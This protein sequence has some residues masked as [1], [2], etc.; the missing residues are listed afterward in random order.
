M[1]GPMQPQGHFQ[2]VR[3]LV[4]EGDDPQAA[5][6]APR[7]RVE[8]EGYVEL[9]PGLAD[10]GRR[11]PGAGPRRPGRRRA[12]PVRRRPGDPAPRGRARRRLGRPRR[13]LRRGFLVD[14]DLRPDRHPTADRGGTV[15]LL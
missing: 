9:E 14:V 10:R 13:R 5:L 1:G 11:P 6:D 4:D 15:P 7:W 3:R 12:A 8:E 2:V